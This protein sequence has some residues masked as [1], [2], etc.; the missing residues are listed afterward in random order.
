ML[1]KRRHRRFK[2]ELIEF[3]GRL[4]LTDKVEIIDMSFGGVALKLDRRLNIGREY[5]FKL[6]DGKKSIDVQSIVVRCR[7]S[8]IE[9]KFTGEKVSIYTAGMRFKDGAAEKVADFIH[10]SILAA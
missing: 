4:G 2:M 8:G 5:L 7:L 10:D 3:D 1:D 9:Q 6:E